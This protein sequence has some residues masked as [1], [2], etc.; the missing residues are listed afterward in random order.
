MKKL[1]ILLILFCLMLFS[2]CESKT[3]TV[4]TSSSLVNQ[5]RSV[6]EKLIKTEAE[7]NELK[8]SK[9][10][11]SN[12]INKQAFPN[13]AESY[14]YFPLYDVS[15]SD[16]LEIKSYMAIEYS[17]TMEEKFSSLCKSMSRNFDGVSVVLHVINDVNGKKVA[18]VNLVDGTKFWTDYMQNDAS[19]RKIYRSLTETLLQREFALDWIDGVTFILN[20]KEFNISGAEMF[21]MITYRKK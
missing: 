10:G 19:A 7:L 16:S 1:N 6:Q 2:S 20:G 14:L 18:Q 5:L 21:K 3:K 13:R 15:P 12:S 17:N 9:Q 4:D 8:N 11:I